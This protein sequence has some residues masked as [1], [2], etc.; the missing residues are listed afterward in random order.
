M[1]QSV[2]FIVLP[3]Y[4]IRRSFGR[5]GVAMASSGATP[6][7]SLWKSVLLGIPDRCDHSVSVS[8]SSPTVTRRLVLRLR[9]CVSFVA[10]RQLPGERTGRPID[11]WT[12]YRGSYAQ[13]AAGL[14]WA[15]LTGGKPFESDSPIDQMFYAIFTEGFEAAVKTVSR[16]LGVD[17][18]VFGDLDQDL[19]PEDLQAA[20]LT[21]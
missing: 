16:R 11:H 10:Q 12:D 15:A 19:S 9:P 4:E 6:F 14:A 2:K 20:R 7:S 21:P 17:H 8:V 3:P 1:A 5:D 13:R 18:D